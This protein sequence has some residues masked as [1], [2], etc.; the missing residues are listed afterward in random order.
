MTGRLSF[1]ESRELL[2]ETTPVPGEGSSS[3]SNNNNDNH[4]Q[5]TY[6]FA[7]TR[8]S[9]PTTTA[10]PPG[11]TAERGGTAGVT[12]SMEARHA[13]LSST[14]EHVLGDGLKALVRDVERAVSRCTRRYSFG[15]RC[16]NF[17]CTFCC[18]CCVLVA[19]LAAFFVRLLIA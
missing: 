7:P 4:D 6:S 14:Y 17:C 2:R 13:L 3:S 1:E 11:V 12:L 19:P 10:S 15:C 16:V 18:S 5:N 8:G 9:S